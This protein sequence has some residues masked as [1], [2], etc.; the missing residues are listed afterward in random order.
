MTEKILTICIC[1]GC[2]HIDVHTKF[3][4]GIVRYTDLS[5][6]HGAAVRIGRKWTEGFIV[7]IVGL[8]IADLLL[9]L[10]RVR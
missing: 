2:L 5:S 9:S 4:V 6:L 3:V 8:G 10:N 1:N 7:F